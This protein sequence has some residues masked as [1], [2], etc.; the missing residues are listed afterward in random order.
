[1]RS[2]REI[3]RQLET[4]GHIVSMGGGIETVVGVRQGIGE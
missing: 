1:M 4:S 2:W 3:G